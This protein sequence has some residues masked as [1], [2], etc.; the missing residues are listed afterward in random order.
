MFVERVWTQES[1]EEKEKEAVREVI[2][3]KSGL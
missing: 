2:L 1:R 3:N